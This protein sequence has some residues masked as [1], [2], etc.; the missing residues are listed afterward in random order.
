[1]LPGLE[2]MACPE[3]AVS[4]D[5]MQHVIN[6]ESSR[7]PYA[8]G[9]VGGALV[10]QP[11]ALDEAL[12][13]VR[14]LEEK[15]YNFSI[16]LAQVNRYNL[17]KYGLDSYEKAFQQCPN[18]RAGSRILA[19]CYKRSGGDW[20]KS[21]SC[22]YS[23]NFETGFRHGYVQKVYDSIRRGQQ[24]ASNGVTPIDVISRGERRAVK[25]EHHP[26]LAS[27]AQARIVAQS[28]G[29]VYVPSDDPARAYVVY[30]STGAMA[31]GSLL[32]IADQALSKVVLGSVDRMMQPQ[33][34]GQQG[35]TAQPQQAQFPQGMAQRL[36]SQNS[37][38]MPQQL[39]GAAGGT[40]NGPVMLRP[41]SERNLPVAESA[42]S[43]NAPAQGAPVQQIPAGDAAFVF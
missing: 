18:L 7:N 29:P 43:Y 19:E 4:M 30:P 16:G 32:N 22:Y 36:P 8:I 23:G 26:Q 35:G 20:G 31:R 5:V 9:V 42:D 24:V 1:M 39:P 2:M 37:L 21:F 34:A 14:M 11:K 17:G 38:A 15:G 33:Q 40:D 12:A 6:V 13:T 3:M 27:P 28:N 41:W 25:V 10:R